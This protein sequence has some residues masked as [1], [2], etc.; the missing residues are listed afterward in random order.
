MKDHL[1]RIEGGVLEEA[2]IVIAIAGQSN[3]WVVIFGVPRSKL[4]ISDQTI[5]LASHLCG[6]FITAWR[7]QQQSDL[8][9]IDGD[10]SPLWWANFSTF[11]ALIHGARDEA[12]KLKARL[13]E[14]PSNIRTRRIQ[15]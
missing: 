3:Q 15:V 13:D 5:D 14:R 6:R 4:A 1:H 9:W 11:A 8:A 2:E 10:V 12:R 7:K